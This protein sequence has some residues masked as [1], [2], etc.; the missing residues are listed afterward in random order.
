M[1]VGS[2]MPGNW[3]LNLTLFDISIKPQ[4]ICILS[5]SFLESIFCTRVSQRDHEY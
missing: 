3:T 5:E 4:T 2:P 1:G